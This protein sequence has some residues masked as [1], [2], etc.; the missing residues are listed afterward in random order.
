M[1]EQLTVSISKRV[2]ERLRQIAKETRRSEEEIAADALEDAFVY[3]EEDLESIRRGL[4]DIAAGRT[5]PH[6]EVAAWLR[7]WGTPDEKPF[8][9]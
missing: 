9:R 4:E 3:S 6:E 7:T 8:R 5:V 2:K 1:A